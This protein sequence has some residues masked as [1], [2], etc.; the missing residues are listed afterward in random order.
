MA[1]NLIDFLENAALLFPAKSAFID[2]NEGVTFSELKK[3]AI[4]ASLEIAKAVKSVRKP[5]AVLSSHTVKDIIVFYGILYAGCYYV[6]IDAEAPADNIKT[7]IESINAALTIDPLTFDPPQID[8]LSDSLPYKKLN[9]TDPAYAI[10]TSGSTGTPKAAVVSH[11]S[12]INLTRWLC[13]TFEFGE[14]TIFGNQTPFYFDAS[15]TE[16]YCTANACATTHIL[17]RKLFFNPLKL[18]KYLD[19]REVNTLEWATAAIKLVANSGAFKKYTPL[20]LKEV[21]FGG[22]NM[23]GKHLNIWKEAL[24]GARF[25]NLYGPTETTVDCAYYIIERDFSD[26][27]SIPIGFPIRNT[28]LFLIDEQLAV[29]GAGVGLGYIGDLERT[30]SVFIQNPGNNSYRDIIYLTGDLAR[31]NEYGELVYIGRADTQVK[32]MG[33]RVEL[34]EIETAAMSL[35]GVELACCGYEAERDKIILF[36]QG[37]SQ[38]EEIMKDLSQKLP[39]YMCPNDIINFGA[40]PQLPN[41]KIDRVRLMKEYYDG[42]NR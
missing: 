29:G 35:S 42:K 41:G 37:T 13:D 12:V 9:E 33:S 34:G 18:L 6:P 25:V 27:E 24:P 1:D 2:E 30:A 39:R 7:K 4:A 20:H 40:L 28:E 16:L 19:E 23:T 32:H 8:A 14:H 36:Y 17:P 26:N 5:V 22:E 3:R 11:R 15:V 21:L 31:Y 10:F 38:A